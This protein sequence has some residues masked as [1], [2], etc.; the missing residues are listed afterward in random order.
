M[1]TARLVC[2]GL[3]LLLTATVGLTACG[4][5]AATSPKPN[6]TSTGPASHALRLVAIGDSIPDNSPQDCPG[7]TGFVDRY[8]KS[9][10]SAT[11]RPVQVTNLSQHNNL[12][13]PGLLDELG[14]FRGQLT[15]ADVIVIGIAHNSNELNADRPC[16]KPLK[17]D[18]PD[19]SAMNR[20]CALRSTQKYRP[21]YDRLYAQVAAW[22]Q[23]K[24]TILRTINR[25]NDFIGFTDV[26]F[27]RAQERQSAE[28]IV[29][30]STMI[31]ASARAHGFGCADLSRAF[32]GP[33]GLRPSGGLLAG[34]YT[35]PSDQG[36][37]VIARVLAGLGYHPLA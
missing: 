24:P 35:H 5:N 1:P 18:L 2:L 20:Q 36:N 10:Q 37:Q 22:R 25:Y 32:N 15:A 13:L 33:D 30:W 27:T 14:Q 16:G 34:D 11:G 26:H 6:S 23:G 12:T 19:W 28:F 7:C 31:C 29:P 4:S 3:I 17:N 8:A 21:L 9:V